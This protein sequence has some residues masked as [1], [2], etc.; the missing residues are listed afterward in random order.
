MMYYR[1]RRVKLALRKTDR[2]QLQCPC[3]TFSG[4]ILEYL[5]LLFYNKNCNRKNFDTQIPSIAITKLT[6]V[7]S[8]IVVTHRQL[9]DNTQLVCCYCSHTVL[10]AG[11]VVSSQLPGDI[12]RWGGTIRADH[13]QGHMHP[14]ASHQ[15]PGRRCLLSKVNCGE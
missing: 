6:P 10:A 9:S 12:C 4:H 11:S 5:L 1:Y 14:W 15:T 13:Q 8:T 2:R 3:T 7:C